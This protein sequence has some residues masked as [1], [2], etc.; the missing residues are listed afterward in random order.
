MEIGLSS[1]SF[2]PNVKTEDSIELMKKLGFESGEIF[3]N[4][5]SE[6]EENFIKGL[7]EERNKYAFRVY[8][9]HSFSSAFEP[10][11][12][13]SYKRRRE[14]MFVYFKKVCKAA[15]ILGADCYT[16]H[17]MRYQHINPFTNKFIL[18]VYNE[19]IYTAL[20]QGVKLA[21]ENVSWCMSSD[22]N[23]LR[24][25]K[26][27]C[28][29]PVNFTLDIK[30]AYKAGIEPEKYINVMGK[31]MINFHIN[32]KDKDS[33]CLLPGKGN[34]DYKKLFCKLKEMGYNKIGTIEV[35]SDN[36]NNLS[37]ISDTKKFLMSQI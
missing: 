25:L 27:E 4:S 2:Y 20:E 8:S 9:V 36:Y 15:K 22:I 21:Q 29:Y 6:Y 30:Q 16:F 5:P 3:L 23:F 32:D 7:L 10:Y 1:A 37:E 11:L 34:V 35:Y 13:D 26:E 17:G 12:F 28:K 24:M 33:I 18:E 31:N 14:D 19:L